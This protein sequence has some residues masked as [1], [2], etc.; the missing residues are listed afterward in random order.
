MEE[1][2]CPD[3]GSPNAYL[4]DGETAKNTVCL[5]CNRITISRNSELKKENS[6]EKQE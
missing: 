4:Y 6:P 2:I 5:D 1:I 3:C